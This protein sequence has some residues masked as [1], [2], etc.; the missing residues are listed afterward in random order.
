MT[1]KILQDCTCADAL[2]HSAKGENLIRDIT[3]CLLLANDL[4]WSHFGAHYLL[5]SRSQPR[6]TKIAGMLGKRKVETMR[7]LT[8]KIGEYNPLF[9]RLTAHDADLGRH[10]RYDSI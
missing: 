9:A 3:K 1:W 10:Y 7:K 4:F 2:Y 6:G 8:I 5:Y